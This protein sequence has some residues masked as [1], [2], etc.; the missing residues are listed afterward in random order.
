MTEGVWIA[1]IACVGVI[2]TPLSAVLLALVS[3]QG[4]AIRKVRSHV[5]NS[6][7]DAATGEPYNLRD[8]IDNNQNATLKELRGLRSAIWRVDTRVIGMEN[9]FRK[10]RGDLDDIEDT[11]NVRNNNDNPRP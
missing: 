6:H 3:K 11:I 5:E 8:N 7:I 2:S 1:I 10:L 9:D 4:K